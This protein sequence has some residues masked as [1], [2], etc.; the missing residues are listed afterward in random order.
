M[1]ALPLSV[2]AVQVQWL[3]PADPNGGIIKYVI[4]Y[5]PVGEGAPHPWVDTD[6][7]NKTAKEVTALN[8]ST[9]YQFRVKAFSKVPGEWSKF[10]Q[11]A[12][13]GD[14]ELAVIITEHYGWMY[15]K[16]Y[17]WM[18]RWMHKCICCAVSSLLCL[19]FP[20]WQSS[21]IV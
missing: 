18:Y 6:N 17:R 5:Q 15:R 3:P 13:Q 20:L 8:S 14:G 11:A 10:V 12:T 7:G 1:Q 21:R 16:I 9:L 19:L 4:E 2:S